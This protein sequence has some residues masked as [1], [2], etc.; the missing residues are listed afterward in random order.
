MQCNGVQRLEMQRLQTF[1]IFMESSVSS[2][3]LFLALLGVKLSSLFSHYCYS[4]FTLSDGSI[5]SGASL[6]FCSDFDGNTQSA[7]RICS[8]RLL[9]DFLCSENGCFPKRSSQR[10]TPRAQSREFQFLCMFIRTKILKS[11]KATVHWSVEMYRLQTFLILMETSFS[12]ASIFLALF[13]PTE[14]CQRQ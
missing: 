1:L 7:V 12:S 14:G 3:S 11:G 6:D 8:M 10:I 13:G 4:V 2:A 9:L 5:R